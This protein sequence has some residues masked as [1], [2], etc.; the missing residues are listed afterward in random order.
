MSGKNKVQG[1]SRISTVSASKSQDLGIPVYSIV[2][3]ILRLA[4]VIIIIISFSVLF[5]S[6]ATKFGVNYIK[7]LVGTFIMRL[8][9][10]ITGIF[11]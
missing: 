7:G 4:I 2:T 5:F 10:M 1:K 6:I 9:N 3:G 11:I 8:I